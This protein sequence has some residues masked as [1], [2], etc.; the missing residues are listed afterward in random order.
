MHDINNLFL[1]GMLTPAPEAQVSVTDF[2]VSHS[3]SIFGL[4]F[5]MDFATLNLT[6]GTGSLASLSTTGSMVSLMTSYEHT[7]TSTLMA[8]R[9]V[10]R[11]R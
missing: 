10:M 7:S 1:I 6:L 9:V 2:L 3:S 4:S 11:W 5:V 8:K